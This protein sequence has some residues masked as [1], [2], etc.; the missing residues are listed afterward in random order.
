METIKF[1]Y[2]KNLRKGAESMTT[3]T[4]IDNQEEITK[5]FNTILE[6]ADNMS[7]YVIDFM[8]T[9]S[10]IDGE[11]E[12]LNIDK[13]RTIEDIEEQLRNDNLDEEE[14]QRLNNELDEWY[15]VEYT[16]KVK[17]EDIDYVEIIQ[18]DNHRPIYNLVLK[19]GDYYEV[20]YM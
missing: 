12:F 4:R 2:I 10:N 14:E 5:I 9:L 15:E 3:E 8:Y 17:L 11:I 19:S 6:N 7:A 13:D 16:E 1:T 18:I 20:S